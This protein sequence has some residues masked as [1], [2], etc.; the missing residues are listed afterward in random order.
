MNSV[1]D[2]ADDQKSALDGVKEKPP[3]TNARG[4]RNEQYGYNVSVSLN[5]FAFHFYLVRYDVGFV[6]AVPFNDLLA[7]TAYCGLFDC[8]D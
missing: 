3:S 8:A 1:D 7:C 2:T 4:F 6:Q 5:V